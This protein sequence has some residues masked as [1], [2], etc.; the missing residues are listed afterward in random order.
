VPDDA[1]VGQDPV[2]P[3]RAEPG[4]ARGIES[5]EGRAIGFT[6]SQNR[7][8]GESCLRAF[9]GEELEEVTVVERR[10]TPFLVVVSGEERI[11]L[12]PRTTIETGSRPGHDGPA[13]TAEW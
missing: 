6:L 4:H 10:D 12:R 1:G 5:G 2:D 11:A 13:A 8:P 3:R 7:E 9:E